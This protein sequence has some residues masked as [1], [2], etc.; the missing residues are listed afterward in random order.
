MILKDHYT[1]FS[2]NQG[3][4]YI[5]DNETDIHQFIKPITIAVGTEM[6][7]PGDLTN[8]DNY[9]TR[10]VKY[11]GVVDGNGMIFYYGS[12]NN[13]FPRYYYGLIFIITKHRIFEM[14]SPKGGR[15]QNFING[16]WK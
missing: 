8:L 15:D 14:Y 5:F 13:L 10:K 1:L 9:L 11:L 3:C 12:D 4:G 7:N 16:K 2:D 6:I